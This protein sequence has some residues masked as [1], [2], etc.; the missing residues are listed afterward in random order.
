[1]TWLALLLSLAACSADLNDL[2]RPFRT[3][4]AQ[5]FEHVQRQ[6]TDFTCGSA[7]LSI[8]ATYYYRKPIKEV[9]FT[10]AIRKTYGKEAWNEVERN[11]LSML[12][13]KRAAEAFGFAAEGLK[14]NL[15]QLRELKG[16]VVVHLDKGFIRHFSVFKG[17]EGER[18]YLAD[19]ISGNSREPLY[20]FLDEWTGYALAIWIDAEE[21]PITNQLRASSRDVPNELQA[22]RDALYTLP[23]LTAFSRFAQ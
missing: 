10:A 9:A 20:R 2:D 5:K 17:I 11:G 23:P 13:L 18:A 19:P 6:R 14:L 12:D 8:I 21:L 7:S 3:W 4:Q 1:M 16:P 15:A 22:G